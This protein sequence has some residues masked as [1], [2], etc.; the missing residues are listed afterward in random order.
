MAQ[1]RFF[2]EM[3]NTVKTMSLLANEADKMP[4]FWYFSQAKIS[5]S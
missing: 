3:Y 5:L 2:S 4:T 1:L